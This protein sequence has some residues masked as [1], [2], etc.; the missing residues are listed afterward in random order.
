MDD[1][2]LQKI[3]KYQFNNPELLHGALSKST[4]G[5]QSEMQ[6]LALLGDALLSLDIAERGYNAGAS[7]GASLRLSF[8][9]PLITTRYY[10]PRDT[11][12]CMQ[13]Q[14]EGDCLV[15]RA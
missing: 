13:R 1:L 6:Q 11:R 10:Y 9:V 8:E 3:I 4:E 2:L 14:V 5:S 12:A 7:T 15:E